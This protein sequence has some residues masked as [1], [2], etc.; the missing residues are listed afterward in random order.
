MKKSINYY[1]CFILLIGFF[2]AC[3]NHIYN[4]RSNK[5]SSEWRTGVALY[6]FHT[7]P[8]EVS[9]AKADSAGA[10]NVEGFSFYQLGREFNN[11]TMGKLSEEGSQ[12][13]KQ[14]LDKHGL[15]MPSMYVEGAKDV[16]GWK[17]YFDMA[18]NFSMEYFVCEPPKEQW[19]MIDRLAGVYKIKVAIHNH[20]KGIS[21]YWH[22][23]SVLVAIKGHSNFGACADLGHWVRSGLDPVK[24]LRQLQGH[25]L[26]IHLKDLDES[27][28]LKAQDVEVGKGVINFTAV[29]NEL[30]RQHYNVITYVE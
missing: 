22:P 20:W 13:M 25:I 17:R 28:N 5:A 21:M 12:K 3:S 4:N 27:N 16:V 2:S 18:Q 10:K 1:R 14:M 6:S 23:D 29:I 9:L 24:C 8:F 15:K 11:V 19:N 7:F 30:K 26:G